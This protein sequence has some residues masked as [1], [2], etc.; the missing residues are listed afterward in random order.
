MGIYFGTVIAFPNEDYSLETFNSLN[1]SNSTLNQTNG[2]SDTDKQ[3]NY[4]S[5]SKTSQY[6]QNRTYK[7]RNSTYGKGQ[8]STSGNSGNGY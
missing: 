5:N 3:S 2:I 6:S 7:T 8:L 1:E 4:S